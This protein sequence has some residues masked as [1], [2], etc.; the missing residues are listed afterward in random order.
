MDTPTALARIAA[1][2]AT[3]AG[4]PTMSICAGVLDVLESPRSVRAYAVDLGAWFAFCQSRSASVL[5]ADRGLVQAYVAHLRDR[6]YAPDTRR[7]RVSVVRV[8]YREAIERRLYSGPNP[9]ERM[10]RMRAERD[11]G[12][13]ALTDA[14]VDALLTPLEATMAGDA[15]PRAALA[16]RRDHLILSLLVWLG[17][18]C[19]ELAAVKVG[20]RARADGYVILRITGKGAKPERVKVP[21]D[22]VVEIDRWLAAAAAAGLELTERDPLLVP[23]GRS[24]P[25]RSPRVR[26]RYAALSSRALFRV[27]DE[28]LRRIGRGGRRTGPHL[29][30]RTSGTLVWQGSHDLLLAQRH[31]RHKR[32]ETTEAHYIRPLI[33]L[34]DT[35]VDYIKLRP[36]RVRAR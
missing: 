7:R 8:F 2:S 26:G 3:D 14:E 18:R 1:A 12:P 4:D 20:D 16:A 28:H 10:A 22:L 33:E 5:G 13:A 11:P 19:A 34:A 9:A 32:A 36:R 23:L 6:G 30:R 35:G 24:W 15:S 31:L 25:P 17:L 21:P 27:V 29:L